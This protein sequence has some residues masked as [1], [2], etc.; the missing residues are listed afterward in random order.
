L[1]QLEYPYG[2]RGWTINFGLNVPVKGIFGQLSRAGLTRVQ[3]RWR[4]VK[5][6]II[7]EKSM[8]GRGQMG[9]I[10]R[11]LRQAFPAQAHESLGGVATLIFGDFC[12]LP[13]IGDTPLYSTLP[14]KGK[15]VALA[16]EGRAVFESFTQSVTLKHVFRQSGADQIQEKFRDALLR[17][18]EY[19]TEED[20]YELFAT[21][22][23]ERL[24]PAERDEFRDTL[25][26]LPT[27]EMVSELNEK[28]L[29]QL[30]KP[31]LCCKAKN[32]LKEA[33]KASDDD[34]DG[35]QNEVLLA[36][37]ARVMITRNVWTSKGMFFLLTSQA[38]LSFLQ[39]W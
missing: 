8:I 16:P 12:Q 29:A 4:D 36:E 35:L 27:K 9:K 3:T 23:W 14:G 26:L 1:H 24:T 5:L 10:D 38:V 20:D 2:I 6:L 32:N 21:R 22:F 7:D 30:Q 33:Q 25:H 15:N 17:L 34:A 18:R 19:K 13:P 31:V 37:G 39:V 11:R 28:C